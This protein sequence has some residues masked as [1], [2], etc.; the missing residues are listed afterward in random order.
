MVVDGLSVALEPPRASQQGARAIGRSAWFAQGGPSLR[1]RAA[2][3]ATRNEYEHYVM[4][5]VIDNMR[6]FLAGRTG[7]MRNVV[8]RPTARPAQPA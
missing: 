6:R 3:A 7:E 2:M 4:P 1:A 8:P 5:I